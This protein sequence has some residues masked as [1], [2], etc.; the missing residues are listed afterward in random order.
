MTFENISKKKCFWSYFLQNEYTLKKKA[1]FAPDKY[2]E[3]IG[4][5]NYWKTHLK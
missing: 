1:I 3:K 2:L 5:F 4:R